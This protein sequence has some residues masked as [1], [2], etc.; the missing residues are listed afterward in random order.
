MHEVT[1]AWIWKEKGKTLMLCHEYL[2]VCEVLEG[3]YKVA[4]AIRI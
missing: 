2:N 4:S 3:P 1:A